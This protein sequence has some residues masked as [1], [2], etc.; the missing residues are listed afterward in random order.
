MEPKWLKKSNKKSEVFLIDFG[1]I[2][3]GFWEHLGGQNTIKN[4]VRNLVFFWRAKNEAWSRLWRSKGGPRVCGGQQA[5]PK[6]A[7]RR[8]D[9]NGV[10]GP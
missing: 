9:V 2:F 3:G 1:P 7:S 5:C 8:A 6:G 4:R 10:G